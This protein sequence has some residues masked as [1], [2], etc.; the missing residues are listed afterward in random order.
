MNRGATKCQPG[1]LTQ[2]LTSLFGIK[3]EMK[4]AKMNTGKMEIR[5]PKDRAVLVLFNST[6]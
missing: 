4:Y 6:V 5:I 3:S 2:P 1:P